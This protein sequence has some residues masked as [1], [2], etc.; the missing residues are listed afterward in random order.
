MLESG[1]AR[2]AIA[3]AGGVVPAAA[4]VSLIALSS[5]E[6]PLALNLYAPQPVVAQA[7][8]IIDRIVV[9]PHG[10]YA[11]QADGTRIALESAPDNRLAA[12]Q[13]AVSAY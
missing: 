5:A 10:A 4:F 8:P 13:P 2:S 7:A 3:L 12:A 9:T 1:L 6:P 11:E